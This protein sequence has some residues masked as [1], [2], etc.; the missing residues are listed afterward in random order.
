MSHHLIAESKTQLSG[1]APHWS[2][3]VPIETL[4]RE[5]GDGVTSGREVTSGERGNLGGRVVTLRGRGNLVEEGLP[6][7]GV[8]TSCHFRE[9]MPKL[10]SIVGCAPLGSY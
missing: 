8:V 3:T 9:T 7:G 2:T 10:F 4:L 5:L 6:R 1:G